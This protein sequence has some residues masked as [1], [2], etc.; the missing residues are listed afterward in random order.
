MDHDGT[1]DL[2]LERNS[3]IEETSVL[4]GQDHLDGALL[5]PL[6]HSGA[7]LSPPKSSLRRGLN[8]RGFAIPM[9]SRCVQKV[10]RFMRLI[11]SSI[12]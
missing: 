3:E 6:I 5:V 4:E 1:I 2:A 10:S 12:A 8:I 9:L 7:R 11:W